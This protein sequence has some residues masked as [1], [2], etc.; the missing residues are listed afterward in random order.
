MI[1]TWYAED[2]VKHGYIG[3]ELGSGGHCDWTA[4]HIWCHKTF[5]DRYSW[6]GSMFWFTNE[7][8]AALFTLRWA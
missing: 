7:K 8:D 4:M 5:D 3:V 2:F 1:K 6:T